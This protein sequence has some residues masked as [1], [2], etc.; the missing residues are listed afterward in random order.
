MRCSMTSPDWT[1]RA[2]RRTRQQ[3]SKRRPLSTG[4]R[5]KDLLLEQPEQRFWPVVAV[6]VHRTI[7]VDELP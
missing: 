7:R 1:M 6:S 3:W 2:R 4:L 5:G